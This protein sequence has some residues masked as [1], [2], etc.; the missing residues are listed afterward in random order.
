MKLD[1]KTV[2]SQVPKGFVS[3]GMR[4]SSYGRWRIPGVQVGRAMS[5]CVLD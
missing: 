1:W 3:P 4:T 2:G 5:D